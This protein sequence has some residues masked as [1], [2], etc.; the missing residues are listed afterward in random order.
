MTETMLPVTRP[1]RVGDVVSV[2]SGAR[3]ISDL[4]VIEVSDDGDEFTCDGSF[5]T[6]HRRQIRKVVLKI[7]QDELQFAIDNPFNTTIAQRERLKEIR[8]TDKKRR[9]PERTPPKK[10]TND[11]LF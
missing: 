2:L 3:L 1:L 7:T 6:Y 11:G 8:A 5:N 10:G 4:T 9:W